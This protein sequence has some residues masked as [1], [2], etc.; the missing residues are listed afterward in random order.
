MLENI[1]RT[2]KHTEKELQKYKKF[3]KIQSNKK[4]SQYPFST[5]IITVF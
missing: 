3:T 1:Y 5:E 2:G 4:K